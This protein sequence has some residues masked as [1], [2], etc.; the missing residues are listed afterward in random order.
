MKVLVIEDEMLT[1]RDLMRTI[2]QIDPAIQIVKHTMSVK[3]SIDYL[4][5]APDLDLIFCDIKLGDG[6]SFEI[7]DTIDTFVP[8][9]FCTAFDEFALEAFK[10]NGIDYVLK[11]F[12]RSTIEQ[13]LVKYYRL[14]GDAKNPN[15][16][17]LVDTI[18]HKPSPSVSSLLVHR[19]DKVIPIQV[20]DITVFYVEDKY[21]FA[22]TAEGSRYLLSQSLEELGNMFPSEYFRANR[23]YLVRRSAIKEV[24]HQQNRKL[25]VVLHQK[26][27]EEILVGKLKMTKFLDWLKG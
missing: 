7:F 22:K 23:Q 2:E 17:S 20:K 21:S 12:S 5:S 24:V 26:I 16:Q 14:K 18:I 4:S 3:E 27:N 10:T 25:K 8:V 11:P 1:A 19:G 9:I 6:L 13:S 15:L